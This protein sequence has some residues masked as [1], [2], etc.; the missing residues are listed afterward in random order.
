R[1]KPR[2]LWATCTGAESHDPYAPDRPGVANFQ[3][4][5]ACPISCSPRLRQVHRRPAKSGVAGVIGAAA[6]RRCCSEFGLVPH[7]SF[8]GAFRTWRTIRV[9][10][11][12]RL[13]DIDRPSSTSAAVDAA[14]IG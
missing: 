5:R 13:A 12:I 4:R 2:A 11:E 1:G 7:I 9:E 3:P 6:L 10:S 14:A 8:L